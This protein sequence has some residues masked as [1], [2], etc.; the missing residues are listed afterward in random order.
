MC[1]SEC[2]NIARQ[3]FHPQIAHGNSEIISRHIFQFVRF[4]EDHRRRFRQN[5]RVGRAFSLQ[6]DG[7]IGEEQM[8]VDDND[9]A[10]HTSPAHFSNEAALPLAAFLSDAGVG[11]RVQL[12]PKSTGLGQFRK[13][14]AIASS[15]CF[16]PRG[17]RAVLL[18]LFQSAEHRL[19]REVVELLAAQI[20]VAA[21]HVADR[22]P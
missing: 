6:F 7:E 20:I 17:N 3:I 11:A 10:L 22:K 21:F 2:L 16:L 4:I 8:M 14:R 19:I 18:D 12:V 9:V 5:A 1:C 15:G 13:F